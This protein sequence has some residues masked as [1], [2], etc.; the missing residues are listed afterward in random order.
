[1]YAQLQ[2]YRTV[3]KSSM[4]DGRE[5]EASILSKAALL[6]TNCK[7]NWDDQDREEKL[8]EALKF[9]QNIWSVFQ[10]ELAKDD[11]PLP[12]KLREDLLSLSV[13]IDKRIVDI[14]LEPVQEK[15]NILININ[16][17]IAAGL[18]GSSHI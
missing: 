9:N 4:P 17:N 13:F 16:I 5:L 18:R 8:A 6:L 10:G 3:A 15:L 7:N 2:A 1:V 12:K 14:L 11:N